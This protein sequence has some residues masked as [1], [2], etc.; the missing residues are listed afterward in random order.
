MVGQAR[1]RSL[2]GGLKQKSMHIRPPCPEGD[3]PD[4]SLLH[5]VLIGKFLC[6]DTLHVTVR[7][8]CVLN[9]YPSPMFPRRCA[10]GSC[11]QVVRLGQGIL[12]R[13]KSLA[14]TGFLLQPC[15]SLR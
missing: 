12:A 10:R 3:Q 6:A 11:E 9:L 14:T 1:D 8:R 13:P 7:G 15:Q 5:L 2:Q 4:M